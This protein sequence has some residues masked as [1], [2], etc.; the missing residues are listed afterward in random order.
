MSVCWFTHRQ[1]DLLGV[2]LTAEHLR[3]I[4]HPPFYPLLSLQ[5]FLLS[6]SHLYRFSSTSSSF[7]IYAEGAAVAKWVIHHPGTEEVMF[8]P[9]QGNRLQSRKK[10]KE[11]KIENTEKCNCKRSFIGGSRQLHSLQQK[12]NVMLQVQRLK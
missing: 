7:L 6:L 1:K 9:S 5:H 4:R 12:Q 2:Y 8:P 3:L 10:K 11:Q